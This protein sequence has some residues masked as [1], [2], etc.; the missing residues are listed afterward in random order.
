MYTYT[1]SYSLKWQLNFAPHYQFTDSKEL[2]N[3]K[4]GR[5]IKKVLVGGC[6]GYCIKGKFMSLKRLR[7]HL[8]RIEQIDCPF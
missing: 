3:V 4:T 6:V 7:K 2:I 5:K 8:Q 1:K